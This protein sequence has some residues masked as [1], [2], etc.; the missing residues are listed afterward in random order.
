MGSHSF[1]NLVGLPDSQAAPSAAASDEQLHGHCALV[2]TA[3]TA[4][5]GKSAPNATANSPS[6][7]SHSA[8]DAMFSAKEPKSSSGAATA[9]P[10]GFEGSEK[11]LEIDFFT[12]TADPRG[13]RALT[14]TQLDAMLKL[15]SCEIVSARHAE[16]F[17]AYVLSESSLFVYPTKLVLKTCGTTGL[18]HAAPEAV[19]LA[20]Q[21]GLSVRR[22]KYSRASYLFP[23]EQAAPHRSF[24]EETAFLESHFS[25]LGAGGS[26]YVLGDALRANLQWHIYCAEAKTVSVDKT[27]TNTLEVCMTGIDRTL[28]AQF[29]QEPGHKRTASE[30]TRETGIADLFPGATIDDFVFEPC[31]YSM[32]AVLGESFATIHVTPEEG[33]SYAS[34]EISGPKA[35]T[36]DADDFVRRAL[37]V[38]RPA[39]AAISLSGENSLPASWQ[40]SPSA[41]AEYVGP[42]AVDQQLACS[43]FVRFHTLRRV[44]D[45][46]IRSSAEDIESLGRKRPSSPNTVFEQFSTG[47]V[48]S[49]EDCEQSM[50]RA[51][52]DAIPLQAICC[53]EGASAA[54]T[55][56]ALHG[57]EPLQSASAASL[58]AYALGRIKRGET[59]ETFYVMDLG[60]VLRRWRFWRSALP[61]VE[62]HYAVKCNADPALLSLLAALGTGFD[63]ASPAEL[64]AVVALGVP[65]NNIVYAN[66]CKMPQHLEHAKRLGVAL[67]TFDNEAELRKVAAVFPDAQ[68]MLRIRADDPE[69]RCPLGDKYG[70]EEYEV[71][72]LLT[73]AKELGLKVAGIA[74]HVGSGASDPASF[75]TAVRLARDAWDCAVRIGHSPHTLDIGGGFSGGVEG[76]EGV[77]VA[78]VAPLMNAT[79]EQL[80]PEAEGVRIIAEPGRYFAELAATLVAR[81]FGRRLRPKQPDTHA[82]WI[83]DGLY[84]SMNCVLYDHATLTARALMLGDEPRCRA[85][86]ADMHSSTV[87]GPTCDG[88]DTVLRGAKLPELD[89]GDYLVFPSMGAYTT[90]AG[91]AFNGFDNANT[92]TYYVVSEVDT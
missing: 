57:T 11:R 27:L 63:C 92:P 29:F 85:L 28:A 89:V 16:L 12:A 13:L 17:D 70:A 26:A 10:S 74:F 83:G 36:L 67:T 78:D 66:C 50:K 48:S 5:E 88:L 65:V 54:A 8:L 86:S 73:V 22:V 1:T 40:K 59:A 34:V 38:F 68:L 56:M 64:D 9:A 71:E 77:L 20:K 30:V 2:A 72:P 21:V 44:P 25:M 3:E 53:G 46:N 61:R 43:G 47:Y 42:A 80:F 35:S 69:A 14:R 24:N 60:V 41:S 32:N 51:R 4:A 45:K 79:L 33:F 55:V 62:P 37:A 90:A 23:E 81:I 6:S 18:L 49:D 39:N 19:A 76:A 31:G 82:Y 52:T 87:F 84:G 91:S 75:R 58:D 7:E 15:A